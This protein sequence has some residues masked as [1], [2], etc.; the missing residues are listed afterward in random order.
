MSTVPLDPNFFVVV[1]GE[2]AYLPVSIIIRPV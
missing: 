2:L 1:L